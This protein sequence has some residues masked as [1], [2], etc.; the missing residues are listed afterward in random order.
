[1]D[2]Y[3][4]VLLVCGKEGYRAELTINISLGCGVNLV[5][6]FGVPRFG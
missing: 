3:C 1:M 5:R 4:L 6:A 2:C